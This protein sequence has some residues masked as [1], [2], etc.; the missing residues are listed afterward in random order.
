[1]DKVLGNFYWPEMDG[2]VTRYCRSFDVCQR[3][4]KKGIAP[5]VQLEKIPLIDTPFKDDI[6]PAST[7]KVSQ[8]STCFA[9]FELLYR[10]PIR[11]PMH[12]L[13]ELWTKEV[14]VPDVKSSYDLVLSCLRSSEV[15]G[16]RWFTVF[17]SIYT[18]PSGSKTVE[19][20][21]IRLTS[22][23]P[24]RQRR[25]PL[26]YAMRQK[27]CNEFEEI[28]NSGTSRRSSSPYAS[29]V[30]VVKE[31]DGSNRIVIDYRRLNRLTMSDPNPI[32]PPA[33]VFQ[34]MEND[35]YFSNI[36]LSMGHWQTPARQE[37]IAKTAFVTM[38]RH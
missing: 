34:D 30:I 23:T 2:H 14:Q 13:R 17:S 19:E 32:I 5:R 15:N 38:D 4:M 25:Y 28:E 33:D 35:R 26:P 8:E 7:I 9:P 20:H 18:D 11:V 3:T 10:K 36:D 37:D 22:S 24:V 6:Y 31:K 1:M 16:R 21:R 29:P 27:L 12:I